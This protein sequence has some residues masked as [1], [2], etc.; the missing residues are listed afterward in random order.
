LAASASSSI[1]LQ[2]CTC[3]ATNAASGAKLSPDLVLHIGDYHYRENACPPDI[4]GCKDSPW[5]Y[6]WD[7]W[8]A[9]L[10]R[11]AAPLLAKE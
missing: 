2:C 7:T 5:G 10:F 4:A 6:G 8:Q 9:D 3:L 1:A 11:P